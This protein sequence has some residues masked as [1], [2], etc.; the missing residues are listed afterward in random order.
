MDPS[1]RNRSSLAFRLFVTLF[2]NDT[3][4][5]QRVQGTT[6]EGP[7][8]NAEARGFA[9]KARPQRWNQSNYTA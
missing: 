8:L 6:C 7:A 1:S 9:K 5:T 4:K 3:C 2:L